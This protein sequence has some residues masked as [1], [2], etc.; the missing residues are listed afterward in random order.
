MQKK[1]YEQQDGLSFRAI[2]ISLEGSSAAKRR[3]QIG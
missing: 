2:A 1:E 3:M